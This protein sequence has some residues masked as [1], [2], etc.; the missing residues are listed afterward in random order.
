[1]VCEVD[2][3]KSHFARCIITVTYMNRFMVTIH[4]FVTKVSLGLMVVALFQRLATLIRNYR[5]NCSYF[6]M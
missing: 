2:I 4:H 5:A 1:M 6:Q 3:P